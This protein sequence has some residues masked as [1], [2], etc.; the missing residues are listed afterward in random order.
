MRFFKSAGCETKK[1]NYSMHKRTQ[2]GANLDGEFEL[3]VEFCDQHV[4]RQ[5]FAHLHDTNDGGVHLVLSVL[6]DALRGARVLLLRLLHLNL[7]NLDAEQLVFEFIVA[8][9]LVSV[10]HIFALEIG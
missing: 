7:I 2:A 4:V 9:K 3:V 8:R 6:E 5:G 10:F 1:R